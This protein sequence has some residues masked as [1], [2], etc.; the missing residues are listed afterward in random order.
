MR[1]YIKQGGEV[2]ISSPQ[3]RRNLLPY[4]IVS[5]N[6]IIDITENG[7][8]KTIPCEIIDMTTYGDI[9][10]NECDAQRMLSPAM[11][12][13]VSRFK[14]EMNRKDRQQRATYGV[15]FSN[16]TSIITLASVPTADG[17]MIRLVD[18]DV[19]L[20]NRIRMHA[21]IDIAT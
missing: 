2:S 6:K 14:K 1:T 9:S 4:H 17:D 18:V 8:V 13:V 12:K 15:L 11:D 19:I 3:H 7:V 20:S 5:E 10:I 16:A 21:N